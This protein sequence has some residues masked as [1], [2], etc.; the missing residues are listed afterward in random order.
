[1]HY[2]KDIKFLTLF[3]LLTVF[4]Q[5][6]GAWD[7]VSKERPDS[8]TIDGKQFYLIA[9]EAQLAW[10]AAETDT[11]TKDNANIRSNINAKLLKDMDLGGHL[12][13][14]IASGKGDTK[15]K[16]TFDGDGHKISGLY[17]DGA[18]LANVQTNVYCTEK[19]K[20]PNCNGQNVGFIGTLSTGGVVKDLILE[21]VDIQASNGEGSILGKGKPISV[22]SLV[23]W[24]EAGTISGIYVTGSITTSGD[25]QG[26][27]GIVGN[28]ASG[29][30][31]NC[32]SEV[33]IYVSGNN[34]FV[35][36]IAG[37]TKGNVNINSCAYTGTG[38][39]N[40]GN[41]K[42]GGVVG[43][44]TK[45]GLNVQNTYY[46]SDV[47]AGG[48]GK[49]NITTGQA[50]G[51]P[52]VNSEDVVCGLNGGTWED[53][54]CKNASSSVW[55]VGQD[56][57]SLNGSDG[58]MVT[59]D[60]NEGAFG[61]GAKTHKVVAK[62]VLIT[63]DEITK[64]AREGYKFL[65]WATTSTALAPSASLGNA[66]ASTTIYAVW[67]LA[68]TIAFDA[69]DGYFPS[70]TQPFPTVKTKIV[71]PGDPITVEGI[72]PLPETYCTGT[73]NGV[74]CDGGVW[75]YFRGWAF[76][77]GASVEQAIDLNALNTFATK[78]TT[79][80]AI[81]T[82]KETYTVTFHADGHGK[83]KVEF[84]EVDENDLVPE[85]NAETIEVDSG[86][87]FA[88]WYLDGA[89]SSFNFAETKI[90]S[91]TVLYAHWDLKNY[92]VTYNDGGSVSSSEYDIEHGI[93]FP[94]NPTK[95][96]YDFAGW[97]YDDGFTQRATQTVAG[98]YGDLTIYGQWKPTKL[99]I[100]YLSGHNVSGTISAAIKEWGRDTTLKGAVEEFKIKGCTQDGWAG[101]D[102]G[103]IEFALGAIYKK[104]VTDTLYPHWTCNTYHV[105]YELN[106]GTNN[107]NNISS[108]MGPVPFTLNKA[109]Y[110]GFTFAG[111]F[112]ENTFENQVEEIRNI[113]ADL[114]LYAKWQNKI[115]YKP[116]EVLSGSGAK[117][118]TEYKTKDQLY[119]FKDAIDKYV[120]EN[121]T[122]DGWST[123]D[124]GGKDYDLGASY[125]ENADLTLYPYWKADEYIITYNLDGGALPEGTPVTY[126]VESEFDLPIP[127]KSGYVFAGWT[128]DANGE[129]VT[130]IAL[131]STG[132]KSFTASWTAA[133]YTATYDLAGGSMEGNTSFTFTV[134]SGELALATPN[135]RVGFSFA[136]WLDGVT[137]D[138]VTALP[139]GSFGNRTLMA[140]W[141][142]VPS[143]ITV[144]AI[145]Q[146]FEYDANPH[147]AECEIAA[148]NPWGYTITATSSEHVTDV[149]D[150]EK[151][152]SCNVVIKDGDVDITTSFEGYIESVPG[153]ISVVAQVVKNY[154]N[155]V[156]LTDETGTRAEINNENSNQ[157][158]V[159][160]PESDNV[161]VDHVI[162]NR[163]F[164]VNAMST[165]MFPFTVS[166]NEVQCG[167]SKCGDF[168]EF[169]S[170]DNSTGKW[171]FIVKV[172]DGNEL[173]AGR[174]YVY[175]PSE[176][177]INFV[178]DK[179]VSLITKEPEQVV[180][181]GW[182]FKGSYETVVINED[183][184]EWDYAYGYSGIENPTKGLTIGKFFRIKNKNQ[185]AAVLPM[186]AYLAYDESKVL[187]KSSRLVERFADLS[188]LPEEFEI[189]I[190][191][192]NGRVIGGGALNSKTGELKMDRWYDLSG[193]K[194]N[195]K[196]TTQGT[197][198]YNGKRIIV[199]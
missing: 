126:T 184:P 37:Y 120:R 95:E 130:A 171:K 198:Y 173:K 99:Y 1:M 15:F 32:V 174:P 168:W 196:P 105:D 59:F 139:A 181:N 71:D 140:Q 79:L 14:P 47:V 187:T 169:E 88:G 67:T 199:R 180:Y 9:N 30:I 64:P 69:D 92:T 102:N 44:S 36:G 189:E 81:W 151:T 82:A 119:T 175:L 20:K 111:W 6:F 154:G 13:M 70:E 62:N 148:D 65:G 87:V 76:D 163:T 73:V 188:T 66:T 110:T 112:K 115:V 131:N 45:D 101:T 51:V 50:N 18:Q 90:H 85:P 152:A 25:G 94:E 84:V 57:V 108:Y 147:S 185:P 191:G 7:G 156:I 116:G 22:G 46:D 93:V 190:V 114:T 61:E 138:V 186:R 162:F 153:T 118:L 176:T 26:V 145:S 143:T 4:G 177:N 117:D 80:Y 29:T 113:D 192:K 8:A 166:L 74:N 179:P 38:I 5:S 98:D 96:G 125:D 21:V 72:E 49:G 157:E 24:Q 27:G 106:G 103:D 11:T 133:E 104:N 89:A 10:F 146:V 107:V 19:D 194:L 123:T 75:M 48:I 195:G 52:D 170:I 129:A 41:G 39:V 167:K 68:F 3:V 33:T 60:A 77:K 16:G 122:L 160:I 182:V 142:P 31:E 86:Y 23:G 150:G 161:V 2:L 109:S 128:D 178:L 12:W 121:Y 164:T 78:D 63:D 149:K 56:I 83:T 34:A 193:R 100:V 43:Q 158:D 40:A 28:S 42:S 135:E 58:Y 132:A 159:S 141:S 127:T 136:G 97:Y 35:G 197:Y 55:S 144:T 124:K 17:T 155:V 134:E 183:H 137:G 172:P 53:G 91:S 165:V 54:V